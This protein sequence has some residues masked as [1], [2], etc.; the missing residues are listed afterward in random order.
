MEE[1]NEELSKKDARDEKIAKTI[2]N[3]IDFLFSPMGFYLI[4]VLFVGVCALGLIIQ[5][6]T[7]TYTAQV[8]NNDNQIETVDDVTWCQPYDGHSVCNIDG[9]ITQVLQYRTK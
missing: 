9:K 8:I 7:A 4:W 1:S 5:E 3:V 2:A 6:S